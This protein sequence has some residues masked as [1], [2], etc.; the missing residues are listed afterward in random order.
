MANSRNY[1]NT[2]VSTTLNGAITSGTSVVLNSQTGMPTPPFQLSIEPDSVNEEIVLVGSG[3]GTLG[4]PYIVTRAQDGTSNISHANGVTVQH[5]ISAVDFTDSR[6]HEA[7]AAGVHGLNGSNM[8]VNGGNAGLTATITLTNTTTETTVSKQFTTNANSLVA[9]SCYRVRGYGTIAT[10][11]S[12]PNIVWKF[13]LGSAILATFTTTA[14]TTTVANTDFR[15]VAE[16]DC[17]TIGSSANVVGVMTLWTPTL[18]TVFTVGN[19][20]P[21]DT[22]GVVTV[23]TTTSNIIAVT[24]TWS[25]ASSSNILSTLG[26]NV[27]QLF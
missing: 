17:Q 23:N 22:Q 21:T 24:A 15:F 20:N 25:A 13:K 3:A 1:S 4:S 12:T 26:G 8:T 18:N 2:A 11:A 19:A 9:G 27:E 5:R 14:T 16:L 6:T 7:T 10:T